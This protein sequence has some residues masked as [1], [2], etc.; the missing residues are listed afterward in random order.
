MV[1]S[2]CK[3]GGFGKRDFYGVGV[4]VVAHLFPLSGVSHESG[5]SEQS[6]E[7]EELHESEDLE[8]PARIED[9]RPPSVTLW[10]DEVYVVQGHG[11]DQ[12]YNEPSPQVTLSDHPRL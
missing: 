7:R 9:L 11:R 10:Y 5:Y 3:K 2:A 12:V 1:A 8:S 4:R 6:H